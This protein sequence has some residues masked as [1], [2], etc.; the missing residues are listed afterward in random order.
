MQYWLMKTEPEEF[1][2]DD[3]KRIK[4]EPWSGVR[5]YA[6]RNY[7]VRD[8]K[9]GDMVLFYHSS[10]EVPGVYGL[11]K[12]SHLAE[13]DAAQFD[14]KSKYFDPKAKKEKPTWYGVRVRFVRKLKKPVPLA[15][16]KNEKKL[17]NMFLF[18]NGRLSVGPVTPAEYAHIVKLAGA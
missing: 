3:L 8:M 16:L 6:A 12:V 1:S 5:N 9:V 2:I 7:M 15:T 14:K 10:C 11:A 17:A 13:P 4:V 18:K